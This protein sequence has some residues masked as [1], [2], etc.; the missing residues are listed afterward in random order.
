MLAFDLYCWKPERQCRA[1]HDVLG[2]DGVR[3]GIEIDE[4]AAP[5]VDSA[6]AKTQALGIDAVEIDQFFECLLEAN[7]IVKARSRCGAGGMQPQGGDAGPADST[8]P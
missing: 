7:G 2:A 6:D 1:R 4:I 5:D 3:R 8:R